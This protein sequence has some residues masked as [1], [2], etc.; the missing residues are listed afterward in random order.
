MAWRSSS[1]GA[2]LRRRLRQNLRRSAGSGRRGCSPSITA[3]GSSRPT[4]VP[5]STRGPE[6]ASLLSECICGKR[7]S[8]A[9]R[10]IAK[11]ARQAGPLRPQVEGATLTGTGRPTACRCE[12]S[13]EI[14]CAHRHRLTVIGQRQPDQP[15]E[16]AVTRYLR[17]EAT[18]PMLQGGALCCPPASEAWAAASVSGGNRGGGATSAVARHAQPPAPRRDR[19]VFCHPLSL[20]GVAQPGGAPDSKPDGCGF[21]SCRP[22]SPCP[23]LGRQPRTLSTPQWM[24]RAQSRPAPRRAGRSDTSGTVPRP[25]RAVGAMGSSPGSQPGGYGFE[26]RTAYVR[27]TRDDTRL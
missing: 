6:W 18:R 14:N 17:T 12:S 1:A 2:P 10:V 20:R 19:A 21:E 5:F 15:R 23:G 26:S 27:P 9:G 3:D 7:V 22:C 16:Y 13:S 11:L 4:T 25:I 24:E 8:A